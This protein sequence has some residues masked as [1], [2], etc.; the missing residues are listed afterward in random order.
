MPNF[1]SV[2]LIGHVG[3]AP[4][5]KFTQSGEQIANFSL[6]TNRKRSNEDIATWWRCSVFGKRAEALKKYVGKGDAL[7]VQGEPC[8]RS[9][10]ARDGS[11]GQSL[12]V[13]V[14]EFSFVGGKNGPTGA[15]EGEVI[16]AQ[17]QPVEYDEIPF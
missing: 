9:Y 8:L 12:E 6:C 7:M 15:L 5:I 10:T 17:A 4:E 1:A 11:K 14:R 13:A 2:T 3:Q 16:P